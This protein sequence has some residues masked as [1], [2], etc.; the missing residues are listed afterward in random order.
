M[1]PEVYWCRFSGGLAGRKAGMSATA[2]LSPGAGS[3][4]CAAPLLPSCSETA[5]SRCLLPFP[6]LRGEMRASSLARLDW[7]LGGGAAP[8][9]SSSCLCCRCSTCPPLPA[10]LA[11]TCSDLM[12]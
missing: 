12:R 11:A 8:G 9:C 1:G 5:A 3:L 2:P 7:R 6:V 10:G 4:L